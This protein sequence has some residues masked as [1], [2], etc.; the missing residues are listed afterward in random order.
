MFTPPFPL[1]PAL[2]RR[3]GW[4]TAARP[5]RHGSPARTA[6]TERALEERCTHRA[7]LPCP[8]CPRPSHRSCR[9]DTPST[10]SVPITPRSPSTPGSADTSGRS[11][12]SEGS[13]G[14]VP[15]NR[16][17]RRRH[18]A[19]GRHP[20]RPRDRLPGDEDS[21]W[22]H[23]ALLGPHSADIVRYLGLARST[24]GPVLDLGSG[25]G[26][27]AVPFA[28]HGFAVEAVDRDG[29][30]L[31]RLENWA[32][33]IGPQVA[34]LIVTT[35]ADLTELRLDGDYRL[36]LLAGAM[37]SA[38]PP[39]ARPRLLREIAS[40]LGAGGALALD[41]TAHLLPGLVAEP[42]RTWAFQVPRF[43]GIDE[44]VVA[45]QTFDLRTM[46]ERITYYSARTGK[47]STERVV[48]ST[49]KWIVDGDRLAAELHS[50]G[51]HIE[52]RRRHRIDD[53]TESVLLVC[54]TDD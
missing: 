7:A 26:R 18:P 41:Y 32:R 3:S 14:P 42:Q 2:R 12:G 40:H 29:P 19:R 52:G 16:P 53:R 5:R 34:E 31:E 37:V 23:D 27:L 17:P 4:S 46:S 35:R 51:L 49:D 28:R 36:A 13:E 1:E 44:W 15:S 39:G 30:A 25:A 47:L 22:L 54:R 38:V 21:V 33:R 9:P 11:A 24:G 50:A 48:L 10:P 43:D 20:S 45:R 6:R 8:S